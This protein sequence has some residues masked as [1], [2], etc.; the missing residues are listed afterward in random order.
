MNRR[1]ILYA[2]DLAATEKEKREGVFWELKGWVVE[3]WYS[4]GD[5]DIERDWGWVKRGLLYGAGEETEEDGGG[6]IGSFWGGIWVIIWGK[7]AKLLGLSFL[8]SDCC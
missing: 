5:L 6:T 1:T 7:T 3:K 4:D 8:I 2:A